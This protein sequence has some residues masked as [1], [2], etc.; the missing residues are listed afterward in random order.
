M[1]IRSDF[2]DYIAHGKKKGWISDV[3]CSTHEGL[4]LTSIE[5][6]DAEDGW[7]VC[8]PA[9]RIWGPKGKQW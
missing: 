9:V 7:D 6:D 3:V 5:E 4:P 2:W 8:V 1:T